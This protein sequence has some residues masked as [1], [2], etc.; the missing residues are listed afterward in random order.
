MIR[1]SAVTG[2][3]AVGLQ[4]VGHQVA[5]GEHHALGQARGPA[6]V[7]QR[8]EVVGTGRGIGGRG[9]AV[10]NAEIA[11]E[12]SASPKTPTSSTPARAAPPRA[13]GRGTSAPRAAPAPRS[14]RSW[15]DQL[16]DRVDRV[17]R[18]AHRAEGRD[19]VEGDHVLGRVG[20]IE[21]DDVAL[22]RCRG[23]RGRRPP[24]R[25]RRGLRVGVGRPGRAV[26]QRGLVAVARPECSRTNSVS[27]IEG[28]STSGYGLVKIMWEAPY[29]LWPPISICS[30]NA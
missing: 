20:R 11:V 16:V 13:R 24:A 30:T 1:S 18:R 19:G 6:R 29:P 5:V 2:C 8:H 12:P 3:W 10:D 25:W 7:G 9:I 27:A 23:A 26:D 17:D 21:G 28:M 14:A 22:G 4:D 15:Q